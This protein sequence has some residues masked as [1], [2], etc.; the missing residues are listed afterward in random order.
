RPLY[1]RDS[2]VAKILAHREAPLPSLAEVRPD[3]PAA[4]EA[5]FAKMAAKRP[6][7]RYQTMTEV[8]AALEA[9]LSDA[10]SGSQLVAPAAEPEDAR[11]SEFLKGQRSAVRS[12]AAAVAAQTAVS[13]DVTLARV[14]PAADTDPTSLTAWSDSAASVAAPAELAK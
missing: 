1:D 12:G 7:D 11:L 8:I 10:S 3:V 2:L 4:V 5:V 9:S 13:P 14:A 6:D